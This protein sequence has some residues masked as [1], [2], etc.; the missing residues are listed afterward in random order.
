LVRVCL[1]SSDRLHKRIDTRPKEGLS[2][3]RIA[4]WF[5]RPRVPGSS[6]RGLLPSA[7][8]GRAPTGPTPFILGACK[9]PAWALSTGSRKLSGQDAKPPPPEDAA[10]AANFIVC[11]DQLYALPGLS[12]K[13]ANDRSHMGD[14]S[15]RRSKKINRAYPAAVVVRSSTTTGGQ[16]AHPPPPRRTTGPQFRNNAGRPRC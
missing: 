15:R 9:R 6:A 2:W 3:R 16:N 1:A 8:R 13:G 12:N 5:G 14:Y 11:S 10:K 7:P 4:T